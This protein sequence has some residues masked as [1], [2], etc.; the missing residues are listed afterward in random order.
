MR[1][2]EAELMKI[3]DDANVQKIRQLEK[4]MTENRFNNHEMVDFYQKIQSLYMV[5]NNTK[6]APPMADLYKWATLRKND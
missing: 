1:F 2:F 4:K 3:K 6:V 5:L